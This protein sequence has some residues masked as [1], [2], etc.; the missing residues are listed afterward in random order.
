MRTTHQIQ[1]CFSQAVLPFAK[2]FIRQQE[3]R[4]LNFCVTPN[5]N[6]KAARSK[7]RLAG[8]YGLTLTPRQTLD[9]AQAHGKR[10]G[11]RAHGSGGTDS[12]QAHRGVLRFAYLSAD[13]YVETL[14][15]LAAPSFMRKRTPQSCRTPRCRPPCGRFLTAAARGSVDLLGDLTAERFLLGKSTEMITESILYTVGQALRDA[16]RPVEL[17]WTEPLSAL[18]AA[19]KK[20]VYW[21]LSMSRQLIRAVM[22]P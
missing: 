11:E 3:N 10:S 22:V 21:D 16:P 19:G 20:R 6:A 17:L 4:I 1:V 15:G 2:I 12:G 13:S 9:L 7:N 14:C 5:R 18:F 8:Q